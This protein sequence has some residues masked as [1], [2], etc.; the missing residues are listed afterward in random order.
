[1]SFAGAPGWQT[2]KPPSASPS[3]CDRCGSDRC[4][5][6]LEPP[7]EPAAGAAVRAS[8]RLD[9]ERPRADGPRAGTAP[10]RGRPRAADR[11]APSRPDERAP[12]PAGGHPVSAVAP[13]RP[14]TAEPERRRVRS[15]GAHGPT[16]AA[17]SRNRAI[18]LTFAVLVILSIYAGRVFDLMVVEGATLA[19]KGEAQRLRTTPLHR[20]PWPDLRLHGR[21]AGPYG[22]VAQH[23]RRPDA[24]QGS[25]GGGGHAGAAAGDGPG[26]AA[27]PA[28]GTDRFVY[29]VK[30]VTP[31]KWRQ[32]Q[33]AGHPG[34]LQR[35]GQQAHSTR[36][37]RW[38][39]TSSA[40]STPRA[41]A[42][43]GIEM[44]AGLE[45]ARHA[46]A[47]APTSR[48]RPGQAIPTA[49]EVITRSRC[50]ARACS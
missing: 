45:A 13:P 32:V 15:A 3:A 50:P 5:G 1:M 19:A 12:D 8:P 2:P 24:H 10:S 20:R 25:G 44:I 47:R 29:V 48:A 21:R 46:T 39:P 18:Y 9:R 41:W 22:R 37:A 7:R 11:Q 43:A 38:P 4:C 28:T 26:R 49:D 27:G 14:A 30:G 16:G 17:S 23:H 33:G 35:E 42:R 36:R 40:T 31:E 6:R 34:D